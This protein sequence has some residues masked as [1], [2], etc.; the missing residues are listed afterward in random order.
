MPASS[1]LVVEDDAQLRSTLIRFLQQEG[2]VAR[3]ASDGK[4]ALACL[5]QEPFDIVLL[6][7]HLPR[8]DGWDVVR[9]IRERKLNTSIVVLTAAESARKVAEEVG[10]TGYVAK[11]FALLQLLRVLERSLDQ[12]V[13]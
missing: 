7:M 12:N 13:A 2:Y 1:I 5:R 6:D 3:G 9:S 10:A 4:A 8:V 11:P